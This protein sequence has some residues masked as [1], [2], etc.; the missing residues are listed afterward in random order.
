M[1]RRVWTSLKKGKPISKPI[2]RSRARAWSHALGLVLLMQGLFPGGYMPASAG[3][4]WFVMLCPDGLPPA[5][6]QA[7]GGE[8]APHGAG[9]GHH[10]GAHAHHG[11]AAPHHGDESART[12]HLA[13]DYCPLGSGLDNSVVLVTR[14][15][16][17]Q[18]RPEPEAELSHMR[19][20]VSRRPPNLFLS[21]A[22]P[23]S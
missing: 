8:H 21:R 15:E 20:Q 14:P 13:T 4:G 16:A 1:R 17:P 7:L 6:V 2:K 12:D 22:P 5:F 9:H 3:H 23:L 10:G 18:A 19:S 11:S